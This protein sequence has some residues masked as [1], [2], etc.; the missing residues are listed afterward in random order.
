VTQI[1]P[2]QVDLLQLG[3]V[4]ANAGFRTLRVVPV[5]DQEE[6]LPGGLEAVLEF[7]IR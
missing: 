7:S 1:V 3:P 5:G 6:R 2:V 4:D